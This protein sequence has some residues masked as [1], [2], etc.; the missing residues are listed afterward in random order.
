MAPNATQQR[1]VAQTI[2][3][4]LRQA[5]AHH[6][7]GQLLEAGELYQAILQSQPNHSEANHNLGV[8]AV[9]AQQPAAGLPYFMAALD[10]DPARGKYWINYIDALSRSG[11]L[12][13]A[14]QVL[15]LARQQGLQGD[16]ADALA[17]QLASAHPPEQP[18]TGHPQ[19]SMEAAPVASARKSGPHKKKQPAPGELDTLLAAFREGRYAEAVTLARTMTEHFPQH[20]FGWKTLGVVYMQLGRPADAL[21]P[22]RKTAALSPNDVEAHYNLGVTLQ[23]LARLQEAE[24]SYRRALRIKPNYADALCNLGVT[25]RN[26]GHQEEAEENLRKAVQIKPDYAEAHNNLSAT[27]KD[28]GRLDEAEASCRQALQIKPHNAAAHNNQGTIFQALGRLE[29]AEASYRRALEIDPHYAEAYGNLGNSL[30]EGGRLEEAEA[31]FRQALRISPDDAG[32]HNNL[33]ITL[34]E[35]GRLDEAD[36]HFQMALHIK[37]EDARAHDNRGNLL[38]Y[39]GRPNEAEASYRK[40]L[41]I[42][43]DHAGYLANLGKLLR[44]L[45]RLEEAEASFRRALEINPDDVNTHTS[46]GG[47]LQD[48]GLLD[49]AEACFRGVLQT[50]PDSVGA[51]GHLG[52]VLQSLGRLHEA[53]ACFRKAQQ[54]RPD[55]APLH[56]NLLYYLSI[57]GT[58]ANTVFSE[59]VRFGEKHESQL[60][61][62]WPTHMHVRDPGRRLQIGFVS[63]DFYNHAVASFIEPVLTHLSNHSKLSLHAYYNNFVDDHVT[64][65]LRQ[66]FADWHPIAGLTDADL[67]EKIRADGI[68]ILIDL[69]GHTSGN[70]LLTFARKPAPVQAS[71]IGYPGTTGLGAMDYYLADRFL[72]PPGRFDDQF[73]EKI[74]RLPANVPFLPCELAPAVNALP[75]LSNGHVTFGS[76]NRPNKLSREVI[77]L[78]SK[79]LRAL[80]DSRMLLGAM[81]TDGPPDA[82][83]EWFSQ[84]GVAR[85]RLDFHPRSDMKNYLSLHHQVDICLDTFPYNGG[86]TTHHALWMGVPTLTLAGAGTPGRVG[87]AILSQSGLQDF[88]VENAEAFV[89]RGLYWSKNLAALG[90]LRGGLRTHLSQSPLRKPEI[91]A[92]GLARALRTMWRRWCE[93]MPAESFEVP[94]HDVTG[95]IQDINK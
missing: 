52:Q 78:W 51:I 69:T 33:G 86:T 3:Q 2:D 91:V 71:W 16:E 49:K 60:R 5:I 93:G 48:Q 15:E 68:D 34:Q 8:I 81:P 1:I 10:A 42:A 57:T 64:Q 9:Q 22:M 46:L 17:T 12:E 83:L 87:V 44:K 19:A 38:C 80:P 28:L 18:T 7:S 26:L 20:A 82:L 70:R 35:L 61:A 25:L 11:Q 56:S 65:R 90:R 45:G 85:E 30:Q 53:E 13:D 31:S 95:T 94:L 63:P 36:A 79:L 24:S 75:A 76:F 43:P 47:T 72:L 88:G 54:L 62:H 39:L 32:I 73:T 59:H 66:H 4:L 58:D 89:A 21:D 14:R 37:P 23:E 84:E 77:A 6:Q 40:A 27:L 41:E 50:W 67:A 55:Y 29:E 92:A 74:A